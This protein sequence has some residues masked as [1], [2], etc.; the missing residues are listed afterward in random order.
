MHFCI[1]SVTNLVS[2]TYDTFLKYIWFKSNSFLD[3][4][5]TY[6]KKNSTNIIFMVDYFWDKNCEYI[7][8][9]EFR[10]YVMTLDDDE[11]FMEKINKILTT[12]E[13]KDLDIIFHTSGGSIQASDIISDVLLNYPY[14]V[15]C[16]VPCFAQSAGTLVALSGNE[17]YMNSHAVLSPVDP[18]LSFQG[19]D[20]DV[21]DTSSRCLMELKERKS[22]DE[23][24]DPILV[25]IIESEF[26]HEDGFNT[27]KNVLYTR[28][29]PFISLDAIDKICDN[30]CTGKYPHHKPFNRKALEEMNIE[31]TGCVPLDINKLF[32]EF[33]EFK[34]DFN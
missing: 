15:R 28:R 3:K 32:I 24:E 26:F 7:E 22:A 8:K 6:E 25:K 1:N 5:K 17:L 9:N 19:S 11:L 27:L 23:I 21:D 20:T 18:Q 30:L 34:K 4:I 14:Q 13:N 16:H 31:I 12:S 2:H 10:Y 33:C 29:Y